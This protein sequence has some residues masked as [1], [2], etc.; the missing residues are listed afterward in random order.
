MAELNSRNVSVTNIA[1]G[2]I[3]SQQRSRQHITIQNPPTNV[4]F[5]ELFFGKSAVVLGQGIILE[6]SDVFTIGQQNNQVINGIANGGAP[7][8][9]RIVEG[10]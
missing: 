4:D 8:V 5:V 7:I 9:L 10:N 6:P 3:V 2:G 1:G